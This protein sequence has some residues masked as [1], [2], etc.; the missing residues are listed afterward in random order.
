VGA[1]RGFIYEPD[2]ANP[3]WHRWELADETR[4]NAQTMGKMLVRA[5]AD[6][7]CRLRMFPQL[8]H[9]NLLDMV[10]GAVT[11]ALIDISLFAAMRTLLEGDAAGSVTLEL[12][13]QFIGAGKLERPLDALVEVMRETRKLVFMRGTVVQGEDDGHLVA[14]FSGIVRKPSGK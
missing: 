3:G 7:R 13:S 2:P 11:L 12:S 1:T 6:G 5:E 10:H 4:F 9:S 8:K 14:S